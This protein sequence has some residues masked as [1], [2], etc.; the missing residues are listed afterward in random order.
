MIQKDWI[1][2]IIIVLEK[3]YKQEKKRLIYNQQLQI[4]MKQKVKEIIKY[5]KEFQI[6]VIPSEF[7]LSEAERANLYFYLT[8]QEMESQKQQIEEKQPEEIKLKK[9]KIYQVYDPIDAIQNFNSFD[10]KQE[11]RNL[12]ENEIQVLSHRDQNMKFN[13]LNEIKQFLKQYYDQKLN[14]IQADEI[15]QIDRQLIV[16]SLNIQFQEPNCDIQQII[17]IF[18]SILYKEIEQNYQKR[19]DYYLDTFCMLIKQ[20]ISFLMSNQSTQNITEKLINSVPQ[21]RVALVDLVKEFTEQALL[22]QNEKMYS[23]YFT[24]LRDLV[25][26]FLNE[27]HP[28]QF[29]SFRLLLKIN[30]STILEFVKQAGPLIF[31]KQKPEIKDFI[32]EETQ[33][34]INQLSQMNDCQHQLTFMFYIGICQ[35]NHNHHCKILA[36]LLQDCQQNYPQH[37]DAIYTNLLKIRNNKFQIPVIPSEFSLSEA[38]RANLYFYLTSQEM[39]SQKQQIEEKQPEEIK[40]KKVK[41]YQ[42]YDPIDAI[43]NFNSFDF[44][45]EE[46]NL[47]ENEIQVLSHRDQNMKF[48]SLNEIKQFL[49]QYYDQK[50]NQIQAD[51]IQQIDRQLIVQSLNIQFQEPNCDIQQIIDIFLSILYKEIEQNYQKRYDYYL[52]TFCMLIKQKISFLMSNQSTQNITEKLINSVPQFRVALVDLVKEF[53]EQALLKQNE[54][55]YSIYFTQLRDLVFKFLNE[56]HPLQFES[57]RLLLKINHSTILEFVKQAGPLIFNKQK[58]EIKDFIFEETQQKINQ[59]SQMN[60]CQ[61]QL[62]FMFYIGICQQNHNHH[63]KILAKLLQ[64]CQQNYPQHL[65]AIYTNLLKIRNNSNVNVKQIIE[66]IGLSVN[67]PDALHQKFLDLFVDFALEYPKSKEFAEDMFRVYLYRY[68]IQQIE[69]DAN[70]INR[71][72]QQ[73]F[74]QLNLDFMIKCIQKVPTEK[75]SLMILR[76]SN[77]DLYQYIIKDESKFL[78][79]FLLKLFLQKDH[80]QLKNNKYELL[81]L[82]QE[83]VSEYEHTKDVLNFLFQEQNKSYNALIT[84]FIMNCLKKTKYNMQEEI[85]FML[86]KSFYYEDENIIKSVEFYRQLYP[87][88]Y[89]QLLDDQTRNRLL[90][91]RDKR[92]L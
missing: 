68:F 2:G 19:Y 11:E 78:A 38:E 30:H 32:F 4:I 54:K 29:E 23:I 45:Q 22:K 47:K 33:Q 57:F 50:L 1:I 87:E 18:L 16:Q 24:Q 21:F 26:K 66:F 27:D 81:K 13:S 43:Q 89:L 61:H 91:L 75:L 73:T 53:T 10:F 88:Q 49:K 60:D 77:F 67:N 15:Q 31:N 86:S 84:T 63:C 52:D 39:E 82:F 76:R 17:D 92:L 80:Q 71:I 40:L 46:R 69:G 14:Q 51:E 28:L 70:I 48:N 65:D 72:L 55:M 62:T 90:V 12:K 35:Q 41:I 8:S 5:L 9:V 6:P 37:L 7:S 79:V 42:V 25:F 74:D 64:D 34:K 3:N 56:D 59:L 20:K 36:K 85:K 58:P 83:Q 44:K